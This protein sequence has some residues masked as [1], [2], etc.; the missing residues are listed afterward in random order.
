MAG[1]GGH[2]AP[3]ICAASAP[4]SRC[5]C[6]G[7]LRGARGAARVAP[8][9]HLART[10]RRCQR[11]RAQRSLAV[12]LAV[13]AACLAFT[14]TTF[15]LEQATTSAALSVSAATLSPAT[16]VTATVNCPNAKKGD[17]LVQWTPSSSAFVTGYTVTRSANGG[18]AVTLAT[19]PGTATSY[20]DTTVTGSTSYVY[21]VVATFRAW[22][23]QAAAAPTV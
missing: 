20:D 17:V 9:R 15:A 5:P 23:S 1:A 11:M 12:S 13:T 2:S 7:Q 8:C 21:A 6:L 3:G 14:G 10:G 4:P 18:A 16:G 19:L 22:T